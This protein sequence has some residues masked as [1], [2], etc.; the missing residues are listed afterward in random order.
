MTEIDRR[1]TEMTFTQVI[2]QFKGINKT[3]N[4]SYIKLKGQISNKLQKAMCITILST[5]YL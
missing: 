5:I 3:V 2:E 4:N 1:C